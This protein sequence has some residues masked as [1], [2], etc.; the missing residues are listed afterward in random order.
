MTLQI[1]I[2]GLHRGE[3][4]QPGI[5]VIRSLRRTFD[6]IHIIGLV[7]DALE[8]GICVQDGPDVVYQIP[9]PSSGSEAVLERLDYI[10]Q[11]NAIDILIPTLDAEI[12]LLVG[13]QQE[14]ADRNI[15]CMLP[16]PSALLQRN[17]ANLPKLVER[18]DAIT[19]QTES[20]MDGTQLLEAAN[21]IGYPLML[22]GPYYEAY[23]IL[24]AHQLSNTFKDVAQRWGVPVILQKY[25]DGTEFNVM[26]YGDGAGDSTGMT[27]IRKTVISQSGKGL[28]G[29]TIH[30]EKIDSI[31]NRLLN[32]LQWKGPV[33]LEFLLNPNDRQYYLLEINPRFPV[34]VDFASA[35]HSNL[36]AALVEHLLSGQLPSVTPCPAGKLF[37]RHSVDLTCEMK[38]MGTL[39]TAGE[40]RPDPR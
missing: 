24:T 20:V 35:A 22:K 11:Q 23:K 21:R 34:W 33:E 36:P 17:K 25:I 29:V 5:G 16:T 39:V 8:S 26:A 3:N 30:D 6:D 4:P 19:P 9:Y 13:I 28:S 31:A 37:I 1:A 10:Q 12:H 38:D 18:S 15:R 32:T 7:Y 40:W 14:L 2:T 27:T